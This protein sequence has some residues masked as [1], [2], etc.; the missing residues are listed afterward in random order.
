[1]KKQDNATCGQ[2][3]KQSIE[4]DRKVQTEHYKTWALKLLSCNGKVEQYV[5]KDE[6]V[7]QQIKAVKTKIIIRQSSINYTDQNT[8]KSHHPQYNNGKN[9]GSN[10]RTE[11]LR[12]VRQ[13]HFNKDITGEPEG[14]QSE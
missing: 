11:S 13:Y 12:F 7:Y 6:A 4:E 5:W 14:E 10:N 8:E 3:N 1:M 2:E 9:N